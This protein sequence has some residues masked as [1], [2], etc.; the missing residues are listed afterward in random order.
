MPSNLRQ[1][2]P[3]G[4]FFQ[5]ALQHK[6]RLSLQRAGLPRTSLWENNIAFKFPSW[7]SPFTICWHPAE[8]CR[9]THQRKLQD[10]P[11][12]A[13]LPSTWNH[14]C[15]WT[16]SPPRQRMRL[17]SHCLLTTI[18]IVLQYKR[19][20]NQPPSAHETDLTPE[21]VISTAISCSRKDAGCSTVNTCTAE[22]LPSIR[23]LPEQ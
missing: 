10:L 11:P 2:T 23:L 1:K 18:F 6:D 15:P 21:R 12:W 4:I 9:Q 17:Q 5:S 20:A 14:S 22:N 8:P 7:K 19:E 3:C 16:R 13:A